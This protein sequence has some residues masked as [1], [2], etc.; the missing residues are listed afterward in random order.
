MPEEPF[1]PSPN[2]PPVPG[3]PPAKPPLWTPITVGIISVTSALMIAGLIQ[4][5]ALVLIGGIERPHGKMPHL[6]LMGL[7]QK[8]ID[9]PLGLLVLFLPGQLTMLAAALG[10]GLLSPQPLK[11]RLGFTRSV[12]PWWSIPLL[13][14]GTI[15]AGEIGGVL[16][17]S[18]FRDPGPNLRLLTH[19]M[20]SAQGPKLVLLAGLVCVLPPIAEEMLFRGYVQRRLLQRWHPAAAIAASSVLFVLAHFDP[21]HV[22][23]VIPLA[24]WLGVIAWRS[25]SVWPSMLCHA[26]QNSFAL[27]IARQTH[28]LEMGVTMLDL[29]ILGTT[30]AFMATALIVMHRHPAPAVRV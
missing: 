12:L 30:A 26:A 3:P 27:W 18:L 19:L 9:H 6:D 15:F 14:G 29:A 1:L 11:A 5:V 13:L 2:A 23:A 16:V 24:V 21:V 7:M 4:G 8:L 17:Q 10:A 28:A 25:D 20:Q 22:L